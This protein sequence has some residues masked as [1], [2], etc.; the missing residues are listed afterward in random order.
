MLPVIKQLFELI[1]TCMQIGKII[2]NWFYDDCFVYDNN[3]ILYKDCLVS[4]L[5]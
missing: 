2:L 1:T 4:L 3:F 5:I